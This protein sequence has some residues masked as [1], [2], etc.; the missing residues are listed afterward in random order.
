[1][2]KYV[3]PITC[4]MCIQ[5]YYSLMSMGAIYS[6]NGRCCPRSCVFSEKE[7]VAIGGMIDSGE[8]K[9]RFCE[10]A[11]DVGV[12]RCKADGDCKE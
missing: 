5:S 10:T 11:G 9:I 2:K 8:Y 1:M 7:R 4:A 3:L 12:V 6:I